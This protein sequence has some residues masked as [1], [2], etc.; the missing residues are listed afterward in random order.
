MLLRKILTCSAVLLVIG[1][2]VYLYSQN[3]S[4]PHLGERLSTAFG[5]PGT[6]DDRTEVVEAESTIRSLRAKKAVLSRREEILR[7]QL[8][9]LEDER[10]RAGTS[11]SPKLLDELRKSRN[12]LV[13]LLR[14]QQEA[15]TRVTEYLKQMWEAE[16]R[17]RVATMG[18]DPDAV[19]VLVSWPVQPEHGISARFKDAEY[20]QIFGL[21]HNAIDIPIEQK[22]EFYAAANGVVEAVVDNGMGYNYLILMHD[23]YATLYGHVLSFAVEEGEKILEGQLIGYT[24]GRQGT[25]GAGE[26]STGP[27]LHFETIVGGVH[28]DPLNHLPF[29]ADLQIAGGEAGQFLE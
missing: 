15:D 2:G 12:M 14:D 19:T 28:E 5:G 27:H 20:E 18:M 13:V 1:G 23:G 22:S 7:Y 26:I 29:I 25:P 10:S 6:A 8:K 3:A 24:G 4:P 9:L 17:V 21:E 16:G 11:I